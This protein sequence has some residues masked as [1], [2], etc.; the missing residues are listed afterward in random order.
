MTNALA[1]VLSS[2]RATSSLANAF[3]SL[4]V[5][6]TVVLAA[7]ALAAAALT[8]FSTATTLAA[9]SVFHVVCCARAAV[10]VEQAGVAAVAGALHAVAFVEVAEASEV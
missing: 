8:A 5:S 6:L 10:A 3:F 1:F 4:D 2:L 9:S 7:A